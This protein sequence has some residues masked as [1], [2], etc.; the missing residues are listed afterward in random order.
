M[1]LGERQIFG[2]VFINI[3]FSFIRNFGGVLKGGD[4][5]P[6]FQIFHHIIKAGIMILS[7]HFCLRPFFSKDSV[8]FLFACS[9]A[10]WVVFT[11]DTE[12]NVLNFRSADR[13]KM[14]FS[15]SFRGFLEFYGEFEENLTRKTYMRVC[16]YLNQRVRRIS[17]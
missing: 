4:G 13:W 10:P 14:H 3:L 7:K 8:Y 12:E 17:E 2:Y 15:W 9:V 6:W 5:G 11:V 1:A 16:K